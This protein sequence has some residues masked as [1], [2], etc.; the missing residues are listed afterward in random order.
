MS[1]LL[2]TVVIIAVV[3]YVFIRQFS[4]QRL[5]SSGRTVWLIPAILGVMAFRE[6]HL[7]DPDHPTASAVLLVAGVLLGLMSGA[8][9]SWTTRMWTD[10]DG[11]VWTKGGLRT[12][13]VWLCCMAVRLG[14]GGAAAAWG[15]HQGTGA[16]TLSVAAMLLSRSGVTLLRAR[17]VQPAYRVPVGG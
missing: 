7:L 17:S 14:L 10:A 15:V 13:A 4:A 2:N 6:P 5:P 12:A 16:M 1:G 11:A 9:W 3:A 8:G